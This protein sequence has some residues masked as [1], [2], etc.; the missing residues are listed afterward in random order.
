M[1]SSAKFAF[2]TKD[3]NSRDPASLSAK[4]KKTAMARGLG[5]FALLRGVAYFVGGAV[6]AGLVVVA[7]LEVVPTGFAGV[8]PA[9]G[10]ATPDCA[11]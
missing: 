6:V 1:M 9:A 8:L 3:T 2:A 5:N 11:L 10:A 7:G 4:N